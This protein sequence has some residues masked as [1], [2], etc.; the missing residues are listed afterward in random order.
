MPNLRLQ[1]LTTTELLDI[2]EYIDA[3][4]K[5][6]VAQERRDIERLIA[7]IDQAESGRERGGRPPSKLKGKAVAPKYRNP[8]TGETW[9]GRGAT[10]VWLRDLL[11]RGCKLD[12]FAIGHQP[13]GKKRRTS[14]RTK[15]KRRPAM[16]A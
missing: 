1:K 9:A 15:G 8:E 6:R 2:R 13:P 14:K 7:R 11:K 16:R 3:V 4:L 10:P 12:E 5:S